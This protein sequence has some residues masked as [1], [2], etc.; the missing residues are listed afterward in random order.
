[1]LLG[2]NDAKLLQITQKILWTISMIIFIWFIQLQQ[3]QFWMPIPFAFKLASKGPLLLTS[4]QKFS[5]LRLHRLTHGE[6]QNYT[7]LKELITS[8]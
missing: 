2:Q 3:L 7:A 1:M 4:P 5:Q 6:W 8:S